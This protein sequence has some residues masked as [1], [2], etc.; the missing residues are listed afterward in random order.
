MAS[1]VCF[2]FTLYHPLSQ[3][4]SQKKQPP[5]EVR[6]CER[7]LLGLAPKSRNRVAPPATEPARTVLHIDPQGT[8]AP[9]S[10]AFPIDVRCN[11]MMVEVVT[12]PEQS[13]ILLVIDL[14]DVFQKQP[15]EDEKFVR[16]RL[17][18]LHVL[19]AFMRA[20]SKKIEGDP[21]DDRL[22][23]VATGYQVNPPSLRDE[24]PSSDIHILED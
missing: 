21:L 7:A 13:R 4:S 17:Q 14:L 24:L 22:M 10:T 8:G 16:Q 6:G 9:T 2:S 1:G 23:R 3:Y 11:M 5:T 20:V 19:D 18:S 12:C 15:H